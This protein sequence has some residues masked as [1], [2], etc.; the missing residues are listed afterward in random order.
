MLL[1]IEMNEF[2]ADLLEWFATHQRDLPWRRTRDPYAIWISEIMLQ[3]TRVAAVIPYYERFLARFP[4]F[5]ALAD[6]PEAEL[7]AHWA[8]LGY[9]Y[10]A[11]NLQKAAR[12]MC[13]SGAF[14]T[15]Y[16][17]IRRL[18]GVGDYTAAAIGSIAFGLPHAVL[19][20]NV[21]RVLSRVCDD[22]TNIAANAGRKHFAKVADELLDGTQPGPF[23][24]AM[25]ELGA[26][27]CLPGN[28]QCLLCPVARFC[29]ARGSGRQN[30]LPVKI[31][32]RRS[33]EEHRTVFWIERGGDLL[34]WQR[35]ANSRLMPGFWELPE[36]EQLPGMEA[37]HK[38]GSFHHGITFHKYRFDVQEA[39]A[40]TVIGSCEWIR[41]AELAD[42]PVSTILKK[43]KR[44]VDERRAK[45]ERASKA[46]GGG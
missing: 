15:S 45:N 22:T 42:L 12:V 34:L 33:V 25:M 37:G 21:F 9:Y 11:R 35:A 38:I 10:R 46:T 2:R 17:E 41:L 44:V 19:D 26:T 29:G 40:P 23:N 39:S 30:E 5:Q 7:L 3:Q 20:G 4:T 32:A 24:Q 31:V 18:P 6:S 16:E 36:R 14:P 13:E 28:P 27:I 43:A 8:G 1:K